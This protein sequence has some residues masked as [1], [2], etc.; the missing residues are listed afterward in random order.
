LTGRAGL[1]NERC[2]TY[3]VHNA[4]QTVNFTIDVR[5]TDLRKLVDLILNMTNNSIEDPRKRRKIEVQARRYLARHAIGT[6]AS[7]RRGGA[8][9]TEVL[10]V[11]WQWRRGLTRLG[12]GDIFGSIRPITLL[13]L[14]AP[15]TRFLRRIIRMLRRLSSANSEQRKEYQHACQEPSD[16]RSSAI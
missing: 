3:C 14:P 2:G 1:I 8:K 5:L 15:M 9:L 7:G 10:P 12:M 13:L 16:R 6:I 4:T 11:I